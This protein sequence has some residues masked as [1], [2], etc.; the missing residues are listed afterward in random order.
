MPN[1]PYKIDAIFVFESVFL[2]VFK[3]DYIQVDK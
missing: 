1:S 2:R 3:Y